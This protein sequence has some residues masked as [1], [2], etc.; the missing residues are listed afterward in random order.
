MEKAA[1]KSS[2]L[3]KRVR[4]DSAKSG[5]WQH[6]NVARAGGAISSTKTEPLPST[7]A[8]TN[9]GSVAQAVQIVAF[10]LDPV[11]S[12]SNLSS[13]AAMQLIEGNLTREDMRMVI[14]DRTLERRVRE[15]QPLTLDEADAIIRLLRVTDAARRLFEDNARADHWLRTPNP[16]LSGAVPIRV[17]RTDVGGRAVEQVLGRL[18]YGIYS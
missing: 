9:L 1:S 2:T 3:T 11:S 7:S 5:H 6:V 12:K 18:E 17:A 15:D 13:R 4:K 10:D 8:T 14:P 16:A